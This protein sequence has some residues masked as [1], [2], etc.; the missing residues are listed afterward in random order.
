[1]ELGFLYNIVLTLFRPQNRTSHN[2]RELVFRKVLTSISDLEALVGF[3]VSFGPSLGLE[4]G[5]SGNLQ[6]SSTIKNYETLP[7]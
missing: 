1:M 7:S 3:R 5:I 4:I 6:T 2:G